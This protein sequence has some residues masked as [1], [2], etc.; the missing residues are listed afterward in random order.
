MCKLG[1][2]V[3][4]VGGMKEAVEQHDNTIVAMSKMNKQKKVRQ[5]VRCTARYLARLSH[6]LQV[7]LRCLLF[8][9]L[10]R[11]QGH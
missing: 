4:A 5:L 2:V 8:A 1:E 3:F 10:K 7:P 6:H 9:N 11:E